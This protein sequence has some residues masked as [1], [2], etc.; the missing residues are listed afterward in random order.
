MLI[1][2]KEQIN[3]KNYNN[4]TDYSKNTAVSYILSHTNANKLKKKQ[5]LKL[6]IQNKNS[7]Q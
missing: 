5:T 4:K 2:C 3:S 1:S 7:H 6:K